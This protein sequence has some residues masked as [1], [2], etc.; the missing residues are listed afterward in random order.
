M[1]AET[2]A[3]VDG[4]GSSPVG[5]TNKVPF[6]STWESQLL[7]PTI[8]GIEVK[9]V[10]NIA[11]EL[12]SY[13]IQWNFITERAPWMGGYWERLIQSM[14]IFLKKVLRN[15]MLDEEETKER[16]NNDVVKSRDLEE[17]GAFSLIVCEVGVDLSATTGIK[18][19]VKNAIRYKEP[20]CT[21]NCI[22]K[23]GDLQENYSD[24]SHLIKVNDELQKIQQRKAEKYIRGCYFTNWAQYRPGKGKYSPDDYVNNLCN[25]IF[26]AFASITHD[27]NIT[28]FK[29]LSSFADRRSRFANSTI[30]FLRKHNF[31]GLDLDWE[32]P[33]DDNDKKNLVLLSED[34]MLAF[35]AEAESNKKPRLL[36]T[37]AVTADCVKAEAGYDIPK[38]ARLWDF[39]NLMSY[40]FHGS[41]ESVTGINSPLFEKSRDSVQMKKWNIAYAAYYYHLRGMPK[42]KIIIG[43]PTYGRGWTI[44]NKTNA[45]IGALSVGPSLPTKYI[46]SPG[47]CAY[48][49]ICQMIKAGGQRYWDEE[50][51]TPYLVHNNQWFTYDDEQSFKE[52]LNWLKREEFGGAFVWALDFDDFRAQ[53]CSHGKKYPLISLLQEQLGDVSN[54]SVKNTE[55]FTE[56][57]QQNIH[58]QPAAEITNNDSHLNIS[59]L[60][61]N[62]EKEKTNIPEEIINETSSLAFKCPGNGI[63]P[64]LYDCAHFYSCAN[65]MHFRVACAAGTLFDR[66]LKICNHAA[67]IFLTAFLLSTVIPGY[68][69]K[70]YIRGCYFTNWAQYRPGEGKYFPENFEPHLCDYV[71]YAFAMITDNLQLTN[72]EWNDVSHLYPSLMKFKLYNPNLKI[73]LS[74]GGATMGT[75]KF[76]LISG[77]DENRKTFSESAIKFCRLYDFDGLDIDW[78]YPDTLTDKKNLVLL[79]R[80]LLQKFTEESI[81]SGKPRLLLTSAVTANHVKADIGY[82]VPELAKLWDF[83]NLMSY[84]LRGAWDPITGMNSPLFSRSTDPTHVKKWNIADA[85]YHYYK[86]GM[87]KDKIIIGLATYGRGWKLKNRSDFSVGAATIG[88]SD[89][90]KYVREPGVC[91]YYEVCEM[92]QAGGKRYWDYQTRSPYLVKDDQWFSYDDPQSFREKLEWLKTEGYGGAFVW[93]LDFDDFNGIFCPEN[94]GKRY[95]LISLM[96]EILDFDYVSSA[97][98]WPNM[99]MPEISWKTEHHRESSDNLF[100]QSTNSVQPVYSNWN[101]LTIPQLFPSF[102][103]VYCQ[104]NGIFVDHTNCAFF[105]NCVHGIAHRMACPMAEAREYIRGCYFT[106]W[107]QYRPEKGKYFPEDF[108][109]DLCNYVFYAFASINEKL[110][111][112]NF[113]WNDVDRLYP[114]LMKFKKLNSDLKI[115][116]SVGGATLGTNKFKII[117]S[118]HENRQK[119]ANSAVLFCRKHGFDGIDIDWEYPDSAEDNQNLVLLSRVLLETF[120]ME[121]QQSGNRR[122]F[123]TSAVTADQVKADIGYNVSELS[124]IWDFMNLMSYDF[125]GAWDSYTGINSPLFSRSTDS[126]ILKKWNIA[127]AAQHYYKRGMPKE[128]I[129]IGLP[130]YGRGWT[131]QNA[132]N[133]KI[134]APAVGA[135]MATKYIREPGVCS[136][137][138]V[139]EMMH[140]G[141]IRYWDEET[142]SPYLIKGNQWISFDDQ[143]KWI[144]QEGYGGAFV[145]TLDFDDFNGQFCLQNHGKLYPL[146]SL[147]SEILSEM[148]IDSSD[149]NTTSA[150]EKAAT[151][152]E[153]ND[154]TSSSSAAHT[155]TTT[156]F[157]VWQELQESVKTDEITLDNETA[158]EEQPKH[159]QCP[160]P[161][162]LFPN[163]DDCASFYN[164]A[165]NIPYVINCPPETLFDEKLLICNHAYHVNGTR[166]GCSV[167]L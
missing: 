133:I 18:E 108:Q 12:T 17:G 94:N 126:E 131:L 50:S 52:K 106:N 137:Y 102:G 68:Q 153:S 101:S 127:D 86:R 28:P 56:E 3:P 145:W 116:L 81:Q 61:N 31:D 123:L 48:Y 7:R 8:P 1:T 82:D 26:Y 34:I 78:E 166:P 125:H 117:S 62:D 93:T 113:E 44:Q 13:C 161:S 138:E 76:K 55:M 77:S 22:F 146:T 9:I 60:Q 11:R 122:L 69:A 121:A 67:L 43:I 89:S 143:E 139:C 135:S 85:A 112:T 159:F 150:P 149:K 111:I 66:F 110:E 100:K 84:D 37:A 53:F 73:I 15:A 75:Q 91:S 128:K 98:T 58:I 154:G 14:K 165:H 33:D 54:G 35:K 19:P 107:A 103:P 155:S 57:A 148:P 152:N 71:F 20:D 72:F 109:E 2:S 142:A 64:D 130:T 97:S 151:V 79:S 118:S 88:A 16:T 59:E 70:K 63:F 162:G 65:G 74:V 24:T 21:T 23:E 132:S 39:V 36:L 5:S 114:D 105:Y 41:W 80:V 136:Y 115:I 164:C 46:R 140:D 49:E 167:S 42:K 134:G 83:M 27:Y 4:R 158:V 6:S 40:D 163:P 25:Y 160:K 30:I 99:N 10:D 45:E 95:P 119:F 38:L 144:K 29:R 129:V 157:A 141:G 120:I 87:P 92:L 32:Y 96:A 156:A 47:V 124:K 51:R 90:T 104:K 147:I